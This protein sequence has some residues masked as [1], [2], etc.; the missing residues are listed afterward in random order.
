MA[1][2]IILTNFYMPC[3]SEPIFCISDVTFVLG[4]G[5]N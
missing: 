1:V 4:Y 2:N 3:K 5:L